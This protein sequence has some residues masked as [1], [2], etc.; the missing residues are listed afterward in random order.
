MVH[1]RD[2]PIL[3]LQYKNAIGTHMELPDDNIMLMLI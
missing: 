3:F 2:F 1:V